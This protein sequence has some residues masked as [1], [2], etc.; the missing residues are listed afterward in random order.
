MGIYGLIRF[1]PMF[2][3]F[4]KD[5]SDDIVMVAAVGVVYGIFCAVHCKQIK[6]VVAYASLS[7]VSALVFGLFTL[8]QI[9][10]TG[11]I[12]QMFNHGLLIAGLFIVVA[13]LEKNSLLNSKGLTKIAPVLAVSFFILTLGAIALP[14]TNGFVGE[15]MIL[16]G[17]FQNHMEAT[18]IALLGT[19]FGAVVMLRVYSQYMF[20]PMSS[21][22]LVTTTDIQGTLKAY[23]V[24]LA[25]IV[26]VTGIYP[27]SLFC[28]TESFVSQTMSVLFTR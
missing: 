21:N 24:V 26:V 6:E 25:V 23:L 19:I 9:G 10:I 20:G 1:M 12:M 27:H 11:T 7:H 3:D 13:Y 18:F 22:I 28:G 17:G 4:A 5:I 15:S 16:L 8:N 14:M 2:P